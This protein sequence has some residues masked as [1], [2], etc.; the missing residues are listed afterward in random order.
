MDLRQLQLVLFALAEFFVNDQA[1]STT[2][3]VLHLSEI[4]VD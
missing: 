4:P 2:Y 1:I 3:D